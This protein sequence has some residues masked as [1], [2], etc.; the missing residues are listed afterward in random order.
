[1]NQ[2][3]MKDQTDQH[4]ANTYIIA[5]ALLL[6]VGRTCGLPER[7]LGCSVQAGELLGVEWAIQ[8]QLRHLGSAYGNTCKAST[9]TRTFPAYR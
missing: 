7:M 5:V 6:V 9:E 4:S 2:Y 8:P 3:N 1:M